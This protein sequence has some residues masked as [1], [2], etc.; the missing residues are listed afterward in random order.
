MA[1][2]N[3][4]SGTEASGGLTDLTK[5]QKEMAYARSPMNNQAVNLGSMEAKNSPKGILSGKQATDK[6]QE[7]QGVGAQASQTR[8]V[9][10]QASPQIAAMRANLGSFAT[11]LQG[12]INQYLKGGPTAS[13]NAQNAA[14]SSPVY[15]E[16][17][18]TWSAPEINVTAGL[19]GVLDEK[20][21]QLRSVEEAS[22]VFRDGNFEKVLERFADTDGNGV[23]DANEKAFLNQSFGIVNELRR[24][25]QLD[26]YSPEAEALRMQLQFQDREGLV[27][28]LQA[29]REKYES[30][31]GMKVAGAEGEDKSL[32][33]LVEMSSADV[34]KELEKATEGGQGLFSGDVTTS[35]RSQYDEAARQYAGA[36]TEDATV[37][38]AIR[39]TTDTWLK[40]YEDSLEESR[41][42]INEEFLGAAQGIIQDLE[43]KKAEAAAR[44]EDTKWVDQAKQWFTD[45]QTGVQNGSRNFAQVIQQLLSSDVGMAP[46]A[47]ATLKKWLGQTIG[48]DASGKGEIANL[49]QQV[50]EKGYALTKDEFGNTKRVMFTSSDKQQIAEILGDESRSTQ[51]KQDAIESIIQDR[52]GTL[53]KDLKKDTEYVSDLMKDGSFKTAVSSFREAMVNN[54][55][56][57][58]NSAVKDVYNKIIE[59]G[60]DPATLGGQGMQDTISQRAADELNAVNIAAETAAKQ[61][62]QVQDRAVRDQKEIQVFLDQFALLRKTGADNVRAAVEGA[63][64]SR[65]PQYATIIQDVLL[66]AGWGQLAPEDLNERARVYSF[67]SYMKAARG[68]PLYA[69][70]LAQYGPVL[71]QMVTNPR[72]VFKQTPADQNQF[73]VAKQLMGNIPYEMMFKSTEASRQL[74]EKEMYLNAKMAEAKSATALAGSAVVGIKTALMQAR[75]SISQITSATP[76]QMFMAAKTGDTKLLGPKFANFKPEDFA[77]MGYDVSYTEDDTQRLDSNLEYTPVSVSDQKDIEILKNTGVQ[78]APPAA[79]PQAIKDK[80]DKQPPAAAGTK[81]KTYEVPGV[82]SANVIRVTIPANE[83][84][85]TY[86]ARIG[87]TEFVDTKRISEV[88]IGTRIKEAVQDLSPSWLKSFFS[89]IGFDSSKSATELNYV[90]TNKTWEQLT[91]E[92]KAAID[93]AFRPA[94]AVVPP[95]T[96]Q[97]TGRG[98]DG[99]GSGGG[100]GSIGD[101]T[102]EGGGRGQRAHRN[103]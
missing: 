19:G 53:G 84:I 25:E 90:P 22:S 4:S 98:S 48:E 64:D 91:P 12:A 38:Q 68:T 1:E 26:P 69:T 102:G 44:G 11:K 73:S 36:A 61:A 94:G 62:Q 47:R 100:R 52:S 75:M 51:E 41:G 23:I 80:L 85:N 92:E 103:D 66:K 5:K 60:V 81:L 95:S 27:S 2:I 30:V 79:I 9:A 71:D 59:A 82:Y 56:S 21:Q 72:I 96:Q 37:M 24:L 33:N 29:A 31:S 57:F 13:I 15:D 39:D 77:K 28:G 7:T 35:L 93:P 49:L 3:F 55:N 43:A 101:M 10:G 50:S 54:L 34:L 42:Q 58:K 76:L 78:Q 99:E 97:N 14:G 89:T 20:L 32:E 86:L 8:T 45:L 88:P 65:T 67:L 16:T 18:G 46:E 40:E 70:M 74:R 63:I 17:T 6:Q 83:N 87:A